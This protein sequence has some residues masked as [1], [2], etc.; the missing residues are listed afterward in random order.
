MINFEWV[1]AT[2]VAEAIAQL[3]PHA[4]LKAGGI[5]L[6]DRMKEGLDAPTRLVN[7]RTIPGL[8]RIRQEPHG[9]TVGPLVTLATLGADPI[10]R[11]RY[12]ALADAAAHV[13]TPQI[14]N[15]ATVGGNLLQR[16]RCWYFRS[17]S[18]PCLRKG[19]DTCYAQAG[20][21]QYHALF[22]NQVCAA[23]HPSDLATALVALDAHLELTSAAGVRTVTLGDF[24]VSPDKDVTREHALAPGEVVTA[25]FV[26]TPAEGSRSA[27]VKQGEKQSADWP[28]AEAAV[29]A[30]V[31]ES[32]FATVAVVLGAA[33]PVP[34]R[35]RVAEAA[36]VGQPATAETATEALRAEL[37]R[38]TPLT[39]NRYKLQL[40]ETI[41]R[42]AILAA[43][44]VV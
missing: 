12:T 3:R 4:A 16:P 34:W 1:N 32:R 17:Q 13:A 37:T 6:L 8:D 42:R 14:R 23:I 21:N 26:P 44:G 31:R 39:H 18:F 20:E 36:L 29:A 43:A 28:L 30:S 2:S 24:F 5:D 40:F 15:A 22:D 35:A 25:I 9:L 33:A 10:V 7:L 38:A 27:Y 19:G 11:Q 41:G